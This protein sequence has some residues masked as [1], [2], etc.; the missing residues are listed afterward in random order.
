MCVWSSQESHFCMYVINLHVR[1]RRSS[2]TSDTVVFQ[3]VFEII[4]MGFKSTVKKLWFSKKKF[5]IKGRIL[6]NVHL[7]PHKLAWRI[8]RTNEIPPSWLLQA[9][10]GWL[11]FSFKRST[12]HVCVIQIRT[13]FDWFECKTLPPRGCEVAQMFRHWLGRWVHGWV[14]GHGICSHL[15]VYIL[16]CVFGCGRHARTFIRLN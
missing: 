7:C 5:Q 4:N 11:N 8:L 9:M 6:I 10:I 16:S 12:N 13:H 14:G 2:I 1:V 3:S 15:F